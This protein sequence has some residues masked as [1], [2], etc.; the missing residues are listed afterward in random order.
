MTTGMVAELVLIVKHFI[1]LLPTYSNGEARIRM[2]VAEVE[3]LQGVGGIE[4]I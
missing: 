4:K 2:R 1:S 3:R